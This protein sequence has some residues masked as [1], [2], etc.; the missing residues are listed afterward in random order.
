[1]LSKEDINKG[2]MNDSI[3]VLIYLIGKIS[4]DDKEWIQFINQL[5]S[6]FNE[7]KNVDIN[8]IGFPVDWDQVLSQF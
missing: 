1:M 5:R 7:H 6:L 8:K 2:I 3:F 4:K